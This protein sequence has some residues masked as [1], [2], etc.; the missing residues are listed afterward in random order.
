MQL[1]VVFG[2]HAEQLIGFTQREMIG[3][4]SGHGFTRRTESTVTEKRIQMLAFVKPSDPLSGWIG[5]REE[6]SLQL[7][8]KDFSDK[9]CC[10]TV[11]QCGAPSR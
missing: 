3:Q 8:R 2:N 6:A 5:F 9:V 11:K 10:F 4:P 1:R 7:I